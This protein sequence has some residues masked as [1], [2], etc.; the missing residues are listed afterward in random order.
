MHS[1]RMYIVK[2]NT[3]ELTIIIF[4]FSIRTYVT[5]Q[6]NGTIQQLSGPI[7]GS[8]IVV[9]SKNI[10]VPIKHKRMSNKNT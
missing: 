6:C 2:V 3:A 7:C 9:Y 5:P 4:K 10:S 8:E 1:S